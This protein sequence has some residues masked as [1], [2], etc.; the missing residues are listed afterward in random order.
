MDNK[1][2]KLLE[3]KADIEARLAEAIKTRNDMDGKMQSRYDTQKEEWAFQCDIYQ[4]QLERIETLINQ[5]TS[6]NIVSHE[7]V[8]I[9]STF[10]LKIGDD[11]P[12]TYMLLEEIGGYEVDGLQTISIK[13][14]IGKALLGVKAGEKISIEVNNNTLVLEIIEIHKE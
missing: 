8:H 1:I 12:V 11:A 7:K 4:H 9:G 5:L 2:K 10:S 3:R 14:P 6:T 13:S